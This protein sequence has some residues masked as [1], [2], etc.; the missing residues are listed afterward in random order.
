MI[1]KYYEPPKTETQPKNITWQ[2]GWLKHSPRIELCYLFWS[3]LCWSGG[4]YSS[5]KHFGSWNFASRAHHSLASVGNIR[6]QDILRFQIPMDDTLRLQVLQGFHDLLTCSISLENQC[7]NFTHWNL[8]RRLSLKRIPH[9]AY[10]MLKHDRLM[11]CSLIFIDI[12]ESERTCKRTFFVSASLNLRFL[13][14]SSKRSPWFMSSMTCAS[15]FASVL[16][17]HEMLPV[18]PSSAA[19]CDATYASFH[20]CCK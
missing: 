5:S 2:P 11:A 13:R 16:P 6:N 20:C 8:R 4:I 1:V 17:L 19:I 10:I 14:I 15:G 3:V 12:S 18:T 9:L 7:E